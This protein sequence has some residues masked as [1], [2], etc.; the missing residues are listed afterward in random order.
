MKHKPLNVLAYAK[1]FTI[2]SA[3]AGFVYGLFY[4]VGGAIHDLVVTGGFNK[5][6]ALAFLAIPIMPLYFAAGGFVVSIVGAPLYNMYIRH[7]KKY[8]T[9]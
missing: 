9:K 6:T 7:K 8:E 3:F 1:Q 2:V 4:S 5:G